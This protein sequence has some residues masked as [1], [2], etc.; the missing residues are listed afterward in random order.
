MQAKI[1]TNI[2]NKTIELD[3]EEDHLETMNAH[4]L[5]RRFPDAPLKP[6][7]SF[8]PLST[9]YDP[10]PIPKPDTSAQLSKQYLQHYVETNFAPVH[11][12]GPV[13]SCDTHIKMENELMGKNVPLHRGDLD[14]KH[15]PHQKSDMYSNNN[16]QN[17]LMNVNVLDSTISPSPYVA[18]TP[19]TA[20]RIPANIGTETFH[21]HTRVQLR[22]LQ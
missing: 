22:Q 18:N 14:I 12:N 11:S 20:N 10:F 9:K 8:R 3:D 6:N 17:V 13:Q 19:V 7:L 16:I 2:K 5:N 15:I 21:N 4:I 1:Q